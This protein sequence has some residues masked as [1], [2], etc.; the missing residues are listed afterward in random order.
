MSKNDDPFGW[1]LIFG[2]LALAF[3]ILMFT[4]YIVPLFVPK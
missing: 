2:I 3:V 4:W 1:Y